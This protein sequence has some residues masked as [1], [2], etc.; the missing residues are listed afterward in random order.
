MSAAAG[1]STVAADL[2][3]VSQTIHDSLVQ[4]GFSADSIEIMGAAPGNGTVTQD[5]LLASLKKRQTLAA[6]D[7]FWLVLLGFGGRDADDKPTFQVRGPRLA[8]ADLKT[9]L[10]AIPATQ[11]VFVGTSDSGGF[12][13]PL[14]KSN[15][16][17]LAATREEG[18]VD[19]PR[20]PE[21]WAAA[22]KEN[23]QAGWKERVVNQ[24]RHWCSWLQCIINLK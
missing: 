5:T 14:L 9:A 18:E 16:A 13:A 22:L 21:A 2:T 11:C 6:T 10:D 12:I 24:G 17:V 20:Y 15:R 4:R 8:V 19:L 3:T 1:T 23:P 7:E